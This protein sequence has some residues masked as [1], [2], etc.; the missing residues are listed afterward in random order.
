[1]PE[2]KT[3]LLFAPLRVTRFVCDAPEPMVGPVMVVL[4]AIERGALP[5][6]AIVFCSGELPGAKTLASKVMFADP[7]D[8]A[9]SKASRR[10]QAASV[11]VPGAA[12][13]VQFEEDSL[14]S[15]AVVTTRLG[16]VIAMALDV[17]VRLGVTESI[18]VIVC[19]PT[20]AIA[21]SSRAAD[22]RRWSG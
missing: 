8:R 21:F 19:D 3:V 10:P 1:M 14:E 13:G 15:L 9:H 17:A 12:C 6:R 16:M 7:R 18:P 20:V 22:W 2:K 11:P 4:E 5:A